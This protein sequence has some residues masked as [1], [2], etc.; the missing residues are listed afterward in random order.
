[1]ADGNYEIDR[2]NTLLFTTSNDLEYPEGEVTLKVT[3]CKVR[4]VVN[5]A[6]SL[7][8]V[9]D[10]PLVVSQLPVDVEDGF[11]KDIPVNVTELVG[12]STVPAAAW[13]MGR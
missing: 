5:A 11:Q 4:A 1:M 10:R 2:G 3:R 13:M 9:P 7:H 6:V 8:S 12:Q